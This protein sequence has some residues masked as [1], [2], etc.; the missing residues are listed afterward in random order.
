MGFLLVEL[1]LIGLLFVGLLSGSASQIAAV[2]ILMSGNYAVL[3]WGGVIAFGIV[4]PFLLQSLQ[5]AH[6]I[7][8]TII[9]AI[10]VLV[11]GFALRWV[12]VNA[13]QASHMI[14]AT[15]M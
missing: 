4:L 3:F 15:G 2:D 8:H 13:G 6:R 7:P 12:M 9:P 14:A 1:V 5:L 11:G 10:L